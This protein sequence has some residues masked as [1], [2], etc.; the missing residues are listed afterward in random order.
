ARPRVMDRLASEIA[1]A[2]PDM[3]DRLVLGH[4]S[5]SFGHPTAVRHPMG[6]EDWG[7]AQRTGVSEIQA[8]AGE[9]HRRMLAALRTAGLTP[10][11]VPPS[12]CAVASGGRI[13]GFGAEPVVLAL[14]RGLLPVVYGDIVL[15]VRWGASVCSTERVFL[16]LVR[17]MRRSGWTVRR[18]LWLGDTEGVY[19]EGGAVV[20]EIGPGRLGDLS[21][22]LGGAAGHDVTGGMSHRVETALEL[23]GL[24]IESWIGDGRPAGT[25]RR[26]LLGEDVPG[27]QVPPAPR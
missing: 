12:G 15:D 2:A 11:S 8:A 20:R 19:D 27:T 18:S 25:L 4:G 26:L 13:T 3:S 23:A 1:E 17:E 5:G 16:G 22:A 7:P 10:F 24:G 9:L 14:E 21:R 6:E